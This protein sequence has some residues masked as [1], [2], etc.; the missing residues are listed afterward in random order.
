MFPWVFQNRSV[1]VLPDTRN[2]WNLI[3]FQ[4]SNQCR[5]FRSPCQDQWKDVFHHSF[6]TDSKDLSALAHGGHFNQNLYYM[7]NALPLPLPPLRMRRADIPA[8]AEHAFRRMS[9]PSGKEIS[10]TP[11]ALEVLQSFPWQGN[12]TE[13]FSFCEKLAVLAHSSKIS[14]DFIK[15]QYHGNPFSCLQKDSEISA[16]PSPVKEPGIVAAGR[17]VSCSELCELE[18]RCAGNRALMAKEL[19]VSRTTLWKHLKRLSKEPALS[20]SV[21]FPPE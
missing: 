21:D 18:R 10:F 19:G 8:F 13:L 6:G 5:H 9:F 11:E 4:H 16:A 2:F 17:W 7:L 14:A 1:K 12:L 15:I 20:D 3:T